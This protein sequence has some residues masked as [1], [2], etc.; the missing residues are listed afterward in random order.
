M[1]QGRKATSNQQLMLLGSLSDGSAQT[2]ADQAWAEEE[3]GQTQVWE[4]G[5]DQFS[6]NEQM[7]CQKDGRLV[8]GLDM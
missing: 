4:E 8:G 6:G 1:G 2:L 3:Q 7:R 5:E